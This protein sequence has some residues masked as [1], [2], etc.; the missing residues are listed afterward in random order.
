MLGTGRRGRWSAGVVVVLLA[1]AGGA[2]GGDDDAQ[3]SVTKE[4]FIENA[5]EICARYSDRLE[6][7][8]ET[9]DAEATVEDVANLFLDEGIPLFREQIA[10]L[11]DLDLPEADAGELEE[12]WDGLDDATDEFAQALEEDPAATLSSE[13]DPYAQQNEF[14]RDYG[15]EECGAD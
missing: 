15:F 5:D 4:E 7:L 13:L 14:A 2:C 12:L 11:R 3:G 1:I 6:A 8:G 10:E 9:L